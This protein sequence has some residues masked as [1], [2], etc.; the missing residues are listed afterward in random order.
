MPITVGLGP[1]RFQPMKDPFFFKPTFWATCSSGCFKAQYRQYLGWFCVYKNQIGVVVEGEKKGVNQ[2]LILGY[3]ST[4]QEC[5]SKCEGEALVGNSFNSTCGGSSFNCCESF[6]GIISPLSLFLFFVFLRQGIS[7]SSIDVFPLVFIV[8][9]L[10]VFP[11]F[12]Y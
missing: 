4:V 7:L 11:F 9:R 1:Y 8:K 12:F 6:Y 10:V 2:G 3:Y 5:P